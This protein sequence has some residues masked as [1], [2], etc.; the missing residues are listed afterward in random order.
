M[1]LD[2]TRFVRKMDS[3]RR[4]VCRNNEKSVNVLDSLRLKPLKIGDI[5]VANRVLLAPM[6]G[7]TD[8]PF[9]RLAAALGAGL[10][11]SEIRATDDLVNCRPMARPR[12]PRQRPPD[13]AAALR[14]D[15]NSPACRSTRGLRD[16]LDGGRRADR[17][18]R[19]SRNYRYQHG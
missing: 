12:G 8:A 9:R 2:C 4:G 13:V 11:V 7:I 14:G 19:R 6:S 15:W 10:V 17:G 18:G 1:Q 16:Q 5:Q 3:G